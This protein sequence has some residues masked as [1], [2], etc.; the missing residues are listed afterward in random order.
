M[1]YE[2]FS[3]GIVTSQNG[4]MYIEGTSMGVRITGPGGGTFLVPK[5]SLSDMLSAFRHAAEYAGV[6]ELF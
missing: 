4:R 6:E 1:G 5:E 3:E 2:P